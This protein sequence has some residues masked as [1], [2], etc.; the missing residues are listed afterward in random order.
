M[1]TLNQ[2]ILALKVA[3]IPAG[4]LFRVVYCFIKMV[5]DEEA[6]ASYKKKIKNTIIFGIMSELCFVIKDLIVSYY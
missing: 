5:Y 2:I 6:S 3:V 4:V 1:D